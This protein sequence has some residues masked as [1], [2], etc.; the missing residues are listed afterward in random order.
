MPISEAWRRC[1]AKPFGNAIYVKGNY[2]LYSRASRKVME[3]LSQ[4]CD[5]FEQASIDEAYLM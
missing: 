3:I 1:P 2:R 4:N 5:I